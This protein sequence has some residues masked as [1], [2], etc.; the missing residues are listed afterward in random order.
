MKTIDWYIIKKF[1]VTFLFCIIAMTAVVI[2]VDLSEKTDDFAKTGLSYK[3]IITDYYFGFLP[4]IDAM[5]FPL[6]IFLAVI[7]FTSAMANRSEIIAI[8]ST[9]INFGRF[10]RPYIVGGL[11]FTLFLWWCN[12]YVLP[13]ANQKWATF[14][15]KY[16]DFNYGGYVNTSTLRDK[17]FKLDSF[18]YAGLRYYDTVSR[19]GSNFFIQRFRNNSLVYNLRASS[20]TW[21]TATKKWRLNSVVERRIN[22]LRQ[23]LTDTSVLQMNFNFKPRDLQRDEYMK[24]K[25]STPELNE[26]IKLE[27]LRG[28][29]DVN[30]LLLEKNNRNANPVSVFILTIIGACIASR[31]IRGGSGIHL[32]LG[33]LVCVLYI[34]VG[35]FASVFAL[36]GNFNPI[37]AAWLPNVAFGILAWYLYKRASR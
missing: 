4:R 5:L 10:L 2:I 1:F 16:I 29:G 17:Y 31:K 8:L 15:A 32:A 14:N 33:V 18:S 11:F 30:A 20:I 3:T 19:S 12:Q 34:L 37:I 25:L 23:K 24:D 21:D 9:G 36:K 26:F 6:F 35:R 28:S 13:Q 22:G 7:F 27:K